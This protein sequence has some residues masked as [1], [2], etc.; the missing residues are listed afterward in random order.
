MRELGKTLH[1]P[2]HVPPCSRREPCVGG[3]GLPAGAGTVR[4]AFLSKSPVAGACVSKERL[5]PPLSW[6]LLTNHFF[7]SVTQSVYG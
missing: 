5:G 6:L 3:A 1:A 7:F 2:H 4:P